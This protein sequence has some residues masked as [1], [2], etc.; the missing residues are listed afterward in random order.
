MNMKKNVLFAVCLVLMT[1]ACSTQN[2]SEENEVKAA[3]VTV[4]E[5]V[6]TEYHPILNYSGTAEANRK[7]NLA[8]S[9]PGRIEKIYYKIINPTT[10]MPPNLSITA[11]PKCACFNTNLVFLVV[12]TA[13][14]FFLCFTDSKF[15][16]S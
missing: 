14:S 7:V 5:S 10:S 6:E 2:K 16:L 12:T 15:H 8:S 13:F 3:R 9:L 4:A 1:T 11:M